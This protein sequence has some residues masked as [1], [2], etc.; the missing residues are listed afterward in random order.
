MASLRR[1]ATNQIAEQPTYRRSHCRIFVSHRVEGGDDDTK[2]EEQKKKASSDAAAT[3]AAAVARPSPSGGK[4]FSALL[5]SSAHQ[6]VEQQTTTES[7]KLSQPKKGV[8]RWT[9]VIEGGLLIKHLDHDS[10]KVVDARLDAGLPILGVVDNNDNKKGNNDGGDNDGGD[11][12]G[13]DK[14]NNQNKADIPLRDQWRGGVAEREGEKDIEPL[15]FTHLFDKLEV[16]LKVIKKKSSSDN[17]KSEPLEMSAVT[18]S[19]FGAVPEAPPKTKDENVSA[20]KSF[21]WE[22]TK[23]ENNNPDSHAFFITHDEESEFKPM[24]GKVFKA[25][26][27]VSH[28]AA[29]VKLYRRQ[30]EEGNYIPSSQLCDVF[31]PTFIGKRALG[32]LTKSTSGSGKSKKRKRSS[33][34][35]NITRSTSSA[36][37]ENDASNSSIASSNIPPGKEAAFASRQQQQTGE[38]ASSSAAG[39]TTAANTMATDLEEKD[40]H[41]PNTITM[42]EALH[43]IFF[44]IRTRKLQDA[45]DLSIIN[46]DETLS[47]LFGCNRMLF[48]AVGGLLLEKQLLVKVEGPSTQQPIIFNYVMTLDGAEPLTKKKQRKTTTDQNNDS[49][50]EMTTRR[51]S[52]TTNNN[53]SSDTNNAQASD[54]E[55]PQEIPHQTML[56]CDIDVEVPNLFHVRT[57]DILRRIKYREFEYTSGRIKAQRSLMSTKVDEEVAKQALGDVVAG[58]GYAPH[59]KQVWMAL[60]KGSHEGGEAQRAALIDLRTTSLLERLEEQC[61]L[62]RGYWDVVNACRSL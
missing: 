7:K 53:D 14:A 34:D 5:H 49:S 27:N 45:T 38:V 11:N 55:Q 18:R 12:D 25:E 57:R 29:R 39:T 31:F 50:T 48:S 36:Y 21:T 41:I 32:E 56:S 62:A 59:Y 47:N 28:I 37:L 9:L 60:A 51:R 30:G 54:S 22:R 40:V 23:L 4:D 13:D 15:V 46:N 58:K 1:R 17:N 26:F 61:S 33:G 42:D 8:R 6:N 10:A 3:P 20:V 24:G 16:E 2:E 52:A 43:A 19:G 35:A 44:Y